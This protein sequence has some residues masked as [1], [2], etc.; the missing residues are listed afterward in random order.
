MEPK[1][2]F[3]CDLKIN[4]TTVTLTVVATSEELAKLIYE[5]F[6][7]SLILMPCPELENIQSPL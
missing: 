3:T 4:G 6:H 1:D 2:P 7:S 5:Q